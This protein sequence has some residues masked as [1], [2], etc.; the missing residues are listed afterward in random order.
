MEPQV[1]EKAKEIFSSNGLSYDEAVNLF[2][3][4]TVKQGD[5]PLGIAPNSEVSYYELARGLSG[6]YFRAYYVNVE[7]GEFTIFR[8]Q[9]GEENHFVVTHGEDFFNYF[10]NRCSFCVHPNDLGL[11]Q[12]R[13][14]KE[15]LLKELETKNHTSTYHRSVE[16]GTTTYHV[17]RAAL[18][19]GHPCHIFIGIINGN[20]LFDRDQMLRVEIKK[21]KRQAKIDSLAGLYNKAAYDSLG[22][23]IDRK[24]KEGKARFSVVVCDINNVKLVNDTDGHLAGDAYIKEGSSRI[25]KTFAPAKIFRVGGD[26]FAIVLE[27]QLYEERDFLVSE[28][29][30]DSY[31]AIRSGRCVIAVGLSDFDSEKDTSIAPVFVRADMAMYENKMRLKSIDK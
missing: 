23:R 12:E 14:N 25:Q 3:E 16:F 9:E 4:E 6:T 29:I 24:I 17:I 20:E 28:F 11:I 13:F 18:A 15:T 2:L 8:P 5:L 19:E 30:K 1:I 31:D 21:A 27:G 7:T 26:E 10:L 22:K